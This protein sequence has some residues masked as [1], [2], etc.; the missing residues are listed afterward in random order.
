MYAAMNNANYPTASLLRRLGAMLYDG[1]L[2]IALIMIAGA[3][4]VLIAGGADSAFIRSPAYSLYL[5]GM[6]FLFFGWFWTHGGQTLGMRSWKLQ[7]VSDDNR[8]LDWQQA[9]FRYL[10]ATVSLCL[11]GL[12]FLWILLDKQ[13]LAWHDILSKTRIIVNPDIGRKPK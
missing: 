12:G 5:Y 6:I 8:P 10:L 3:P 11:F 4:P 9:L 7:L 2:L 1:L 13:Q